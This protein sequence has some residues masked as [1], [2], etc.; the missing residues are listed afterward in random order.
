MGC[1]F[2]DRMLVCSACMESGRGTSGQQVGCLCSTVSHL[3]L[4]HVR[5]LYKAVAKAILAPHTSNL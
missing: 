1:T 2:E 4:V 3:R 5:G